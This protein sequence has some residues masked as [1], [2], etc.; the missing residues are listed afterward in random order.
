MGM[1][2]NVHCARCTYRTSTTLGGGREDFE[3][4]SE[5]PIHCRDCEEITT[6]NTTVDP[7]ICLKCSG[8][9]VTLYADGNLVEHAT[10]DT[11]RWGK[12]TLTNGKYYCPKCGQFAVRFGDGQY[13]SAQ[14]MFD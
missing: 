1:I 9:D 13:G 3:T 11:Q 8:T 5:W 12:L 2:L 7:Q 14:M 10:F 6:T 4:F